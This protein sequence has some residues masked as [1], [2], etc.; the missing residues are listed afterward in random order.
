[1]FPGYPIPDS[2]VLARSSGLADQDVVVLVIVA[3]NLKTKALEANQ[4]APLII[5]ATTRQG[6]QCV[7]DARK[8]SAN[9]SLADPVAVAKARIDAI[10]RAQPAKAA[11]EDETDKPE[12]PRSDEE[13]PLAANL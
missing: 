1:V 5:D 10:R 2:R 3:A 11:P 4:L 6:A 13:L 8:F 7:L 9:A 12:R